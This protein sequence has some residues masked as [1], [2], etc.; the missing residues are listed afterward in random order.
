MKEESPL[1]VLDGWLSHGSRRLIKVSLQLAQC[2][3]KDFFEYLGLPTLVDVTEKQQLPTMN[4]VRVLRVLIVV[5][6][7]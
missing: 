2:S 3:G 1:F 7:K 4:E 5:R 6:V